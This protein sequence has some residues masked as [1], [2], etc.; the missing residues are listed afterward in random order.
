MNQIFPS[1]WE[2]IRALCKE[3]EPFQ[4]IEALFKQSSMQLA[5]SQLSN[6]T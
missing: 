3:H 4:V 1:W 2:E 6:G 5:R